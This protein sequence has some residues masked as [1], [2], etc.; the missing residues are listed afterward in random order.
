MQRAHV[1]VHECVW[2]NGCFCGQCNDQSKSSTLIELHPLICPTS[3]PPVVKF[4][5]LY[6]ITKPDIAGSS[7]SV[8]SCPD[9]DP[10]WKVLL[11]GVG[12]QHGYQQRAVQQRALN[13]VHWSYKRAPTSKRRPPNHWCV[14]GWGKQP[15]SA[16]VI[17]L[18]AKPI[19]FLKPGAWHGCQWNGELRLERD[20][21]R[22]T[23][24]IIPCNTIITQAVHISNGIHVQVD[25]TAMSD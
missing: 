13:T 10:H 1:H 11:A 4:H 3:A 14:H 17:V 19:S 12:H 2:M 24:H 18:R 9:I 22:S 6:L 8:L 20:A 25:T 16:I 21:S 5:S 23:A 7:S 15:A